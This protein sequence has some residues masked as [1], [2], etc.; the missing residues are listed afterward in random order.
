MSES[1]PPFLAAAGSPGVTGCQLGHGGSRSPTIRAAG[2]A[3]R[4][5]IGAWVLILY[6]P[7][8]DA[9]FVSYSEMSAAY[10]FL[11]P[12]PLHPSRKT[13]FVCVFWWPPNAMEIFG[14][15]AAAE[16]GACCR[17]KQLKI[18]CRGF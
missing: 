10:L 4:V 8:S 5:V 9:P 12:K 16:V 7:R 18:T 13:I 11:F 6:F 2:A 3:P 17:S 14:Q 15:G 1:N